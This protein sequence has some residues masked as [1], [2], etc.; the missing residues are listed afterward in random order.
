MSGGKR[1]RRESLARLSAAALEQLEAFRGRL[2]DVKQS[3]R[4]AY[5]A[6]ARELLLF[7]Q[8]RGCAVSATSVEDWKAFEAEVHALCE[9]GEVGKSWVPAG[10]VGARRFLC[11]HGADLSPDLLLIVAT[12]IDVRQRVA[13]AQDARE[14]EIVREVETFLTSRATLGYRYTS[15]LREGVWRLLRLLAA[16]GRRVPDMTREDWDDYRREVLADRRFTNPKMVVSGASVY[17]QAK[18]RQG[19][20][21][22][23]PVPPLKTMRRCSPVLPADLTA[24]VKALGEGMAVH[25][26]KPSSRRNYARAVED[27]LAWANADHGVLSVNDVTREMLTAYRLRLQAEPG[28]KGK[29]LALMTQIGILSGLRFFF[30]WL[31]KTGRLLSDPTLHLPQPKAPRYLPRSLKVV[32]ITRFIRSLPKTPLGLRDRA[33]VELLWGTGMRRSEISKLDLAD[34]DFDQRTILIRE[35]KGRKDR[36]VPLGKKAKE[37][38]LEYVEKARPKLLRGDDPGAVFVGQDGRRIGR[39]HVTDRVRKLGVKI[40]LKIAPHLLRHSC[41]TH[42]LKRRADIRHI[43]KLLGHTSL[44]TTERYTK[45]ETADLRA[46]IQRC[47][48]REKGE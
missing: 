34:V 16:R 30:S 35:G 6:G 43:Q 11:E 13:I 28:V 32:D 38:L 19:V 15:A 1:R 31:V 45:V 33:M 22:R 17:L 26:L 3:A 27:F 41:A 48:P 23:S 2:S 40:R 20:L 36:M 42:L 5:V 7:L 25:D 29:P 14:A 8:S 37:V 18:V 4:S 24:S 10:L 12:T 47:H 9:R 44:Q 21:K 46:V 39:N